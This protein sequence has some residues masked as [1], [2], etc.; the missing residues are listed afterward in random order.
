MTHS[1]NERI[2]DTTAAH[3]TQATIS[4]ETAAKTRTDRIKAAKKVNPTFNFTATQDQFSQFET[5]LYL[6]VFGNGTKGHARTDWVLTMFRESIPS[7]TL[8]R[9]VTRLICYNRRGAPSV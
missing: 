6:G 5:A 4:L 2:F 7:G 9:R 8:R 3:F 1:F